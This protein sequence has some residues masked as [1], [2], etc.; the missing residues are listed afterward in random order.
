MCGIID[1]GHFNKLQFFRSSWFIFN[2]VGKLQSYKVTGESCCLGPMEVPYRLCL[3]FIFFFGENAE[4]G[5]GAA[6]AEALPLQASWE[7]AF[8]S[9]G[10]LFS[11]IPQGLFQ[12]CGQGFCICLPW[13][14]LLTLNSNKVVQL[15]PYFQITC[16]IV[17]PTVQKKTIQ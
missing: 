12:A 13:P 15:S 16:E 8:L 10:Y 11:S 9:V 3:S 6:W 2:L 17:A 1:K 4:K 14:L 5:S 7:L